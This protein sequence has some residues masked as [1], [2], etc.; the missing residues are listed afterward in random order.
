MLGQ[1]CS[2]VLDGDNS[3]QISAYR[4]EFNFSPFG[5]I[6]GSDKVC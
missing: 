1:F 4:R 6:K 3:D 2:P 5:R